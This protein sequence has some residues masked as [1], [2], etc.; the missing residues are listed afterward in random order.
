MLMCSLASESWYAGSG[1]MCSECSF[2]YMLLSLFAKMQN[3][4]ISSLHMQVF[5]LEV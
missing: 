4:F 3:M 5:S 2:L 1:V